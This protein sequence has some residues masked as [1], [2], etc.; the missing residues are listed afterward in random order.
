VS[1]VVCSCGSDSTNS[2]LSVTE[3]MVAVTGDGQVGLWNS[4]VAIAPSVRVTDG[5]G[6]PVAGVVVTFA[7][8][9]PVGALVTGATQT[10]GAD[11][12][13][14]VGAWQLGPPGA[15]VLTATA[16]GVT[17]SPAHFTATSVDNILVGIAEGANQSA[18]AGT[19]V[20]SPL[21][22]SVSSGYAQAPIVGATVTFAVTGGTGSVTGAATST[23]PRGIATAGG[24]MLGPGANQLTAT[25]T[26]PAVPGG[27]WTTSFTATGTP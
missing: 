7:A 3:T 9:S 10:T 17:G 15:N 20:S 21:S 23:N 12:T 13:A 18:K 5:A 14:T 19:A 6:S 27:P 22:I 25:V 24:W 2:T 26:W 1:F 16:S 8:S 4:N 11:G